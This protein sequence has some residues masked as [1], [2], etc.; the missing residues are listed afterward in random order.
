MDLNGLKAAAKSVRAL[1]IDGVQKANSGHPGMPMGNA[2]VASLLYGEIMKHNPADSSWI[3]RDRFVL[4]AGHGS[5]LLYSILHLAGYK[6]T[7][8]DLK[9]FRQLGSK[10]PGHPEYGYTDGVD[11]TTGPLGAGISNAVG[12]AVAETILA[13][14]FNTPEHTVID[15]YTYAINGDGCMME[16][17]ASEAASLAGHLGL[18]KLILFYDSN[19]IT[20]EGETDLAFS[21]DVAKRFDA[22]GWQVLN[23]D[24]FDFEE[25]SA[26]VAEAKAET[27]KPTMIIMKGVIGKGAATMEGSHHTHGAPL[28][29]E[30]IKKTREKLGIPVSQ[31]FYVDPEA[32]KFFEDVRAKGASA[33]EAWNKTFEAWAAANKE[34]KAEWDAWLADEIKIADSAMPEY[35]IGDSVATRVSGEKAINA[36]ADVMPNLF[37]GSADLGPSNKTVLKSKGDYSATDRSGRNFHFGIREHGMGGIVNGM[38]LHGGI[39]GYGST[40]L[41]FADYMRPAVRLAALMGLPTIWVFTHDSIF[42]GEDGPTHQPIEHLASLRVIPNVQVLRP[43]D[44]EETNVAWQMAAEA[45][46]K[47]TVLALT[48]QNLTV[49]EKADKDWKA[50][51][52]RGAYIVKDCEGTPDLVIAAT[53]SEVNLALDA[54]EGSAMKIRIVSIADLNT[55][56]AQDKAFRESVIPAGVRVVT[57]EAGVSYGWEKLASSSDDVFCIERFGESGPAAKVA[58]HLGFDAAGLKKVIEK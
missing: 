28:G 14:K 16:G 39:R 38:T 15:H 17:V 54:S 26:K 37:G 23:A 21:E 50:N 4:S 42:V 24:A 33:Y 6:L 30:E 44:G 34:L 56:M 10:T 3:D 41:V 9:N 43:A 45:T 13:E 12:M 25:L 8:E 32:V 22:Y 31:D 36:V 49:F 1:S 27:S 47:P 46:D 19:R 55:F 35:K 53:G 18:G 52:R 29:D 7:L 51:Y 57:A 58:E 2:E 20:I 40:F 11:T 48:R 5:M